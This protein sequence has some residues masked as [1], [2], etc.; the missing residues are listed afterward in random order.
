MSYQHSLADGSALS[1]PVG[2][3]VCIGRNYAEHAK[4]LNNEVPTEPL[5]FI[6]PA[7]AIVPMDTPITVPRE[8]GEVHFETE[9]AIL[10]GERMTDVDE[11]AAQHG[12]AG[13]GLALDLTL[14]EL[15][16][17][18]K[19]KGHPWERAK[20]FDGSCPVSPFLT[21]ATVGDLNDVQIRLT[22][23]GDVRQDG[24]SAQMIT[25]ILKL[26]S[27]ASKWFTLEPGD[28]ILTG[29]PAGVGELKVGDKLCVEIVDLL[30][31]ET[32][33]K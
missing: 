32:E 29:T 5:L 9:L 33:A 11:Q 3:V 10:I 21:P 17:E 24:N 6:K 22:V 14:R 16:S 23:D 1:L 12:I 18:L 7:S 27:H 19:S 8:R 28:V 2:K 25:P 15:Q 30:R 20:A 26:I 4:E 31:I 13:I